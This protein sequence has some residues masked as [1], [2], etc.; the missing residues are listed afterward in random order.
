MEI[1][2]K[3]PSEL[4]PYLKN[5]R[6]NEAAVDKVARS[7]SEFGFRQPIVIDT[8]NTIIVGHVRWKASLKLNLEKV[9]VHIAKDLSPEKIKAY[10][11]ADNKTAEFAKWDI[12]LLT[13]EL[14]DLQSLD[15]DLDILGFSAEEIESMLG[16]F[17]GEGLTDPDEIPEMPDDAITKPGNLWALGNHRLLCGDSSKIEDVDKLINGAIIHMVNTD[18]PYN[19]G[20]SS[21]S[22]NALA[23]AN[24]TGNFTGDQLFHIKINKNKHAG[25]SKPTSN[26]LKPKDRPLICDALPEK[27]YEEMLQKWFYNIARVLKPGGSFYIWGGFGNTKNYRIALENNKLY[28]SQTIIWVKNAPVLTQKDFLCKHEWCFYGWKEGAGHYFNPEINNA[29][30]VWDVK[31]VNGLDK[32]H[33]TEKPVEL[34]IRAL[35]YSSKQG[36]NVLDLFGGSGSTLIGAEKLNRNAYLIEIDTLYCDVIIKRWEDY[37][38]Q[39]AKLIG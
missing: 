17:N 16:V 12:D 39:K 5:P 22:N 3:K 35:T 33:L 29:T 6:I 31:K 36:E 27:K 10:R 1:I 2:Y 19:V 25:T 38:G 13:D 11:I 15:F 9:P 18:P 37:T 32:V 26:K 20:I 4:K 14:S 30:D 8:D 23:L 21:R 24:A 7:I 34:A 28:C